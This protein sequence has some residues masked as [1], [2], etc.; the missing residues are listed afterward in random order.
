MGQN[1]DKL[2]GEEQ[3]LSAVPEETSPDPNSASAGDVMEGGSSRE[4]AAGNSGENRG[5]PDAGDPDGCSSQENTHLWVRPFAASEVRQGGA[6][7]KASRGGG[8]VGGWANES[9]RRETEE[10]PKCSPELEETARAYKLH[11]Q[12]KKERDS[13]EGEPH[14][15]EAE[16]E[17]RCSPPDETQDQHL[18][19]DHAFGSEDANALDGSGGDQ[20]SPGT[21]ASG[22]Q[23]IRGHSSSV[24]QDESDSIMAGTA[25]GDIKPSPGTVGR[26]SRRKDPP[27][28][29]SPHPLKN[30]EKKEPLSDMSDSIHSRPANGR[31]GGATK[32]GAPAQEAQSQF[33][34]T[35]PND[36]GTRRSEA[37]D[38]GASS[39]SAAS[40]TSNAEPS[41]I[42]EKLLMRNKKQTILSVVREADMSETDGVDDAARGTVDTTA[43]ELPRAAADKSTIN[44][45]LSTWN[46]KRMDEEPGLGNAADKDRHIKGQDM[47]QPDTSLSP[48][49]TENIKCENSLTNPKSARAQ[50]SKDNQTA[51]LVCDPKLPAKGDVQSGDSLPAEKSN[52]PPAPPKK[53]E[54]ENDSDQTHAVKAGVTQ[55]VGNESSQGPGENVVKRNKK[56]RDDSQDLPK[57]R[58]VSELIKET[59]QLHEKLL[60]QEWS[61]PAEVKG[62]EQGQSVKVAQMK[63]AFDLAQKSPDK[64]IE[65]KPSVRRGK[66]KI[67]L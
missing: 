60:H 13:A 8:G 29:Q 32:E 66:G 65:R 37:A 67:L 45:L 1:Q 3:V 4:A 9:D 30:S 10:N 11:N 50:S 49:V 53:S 55:H 26:L 34:P 43:T 59:M 61:K 22:A 44:T 64:S 31:T 62:E 56:E 17:E 25:A 63:A 57:S 40:P 36:P 58:P 24:E 20:A 23:A 12:T 7:G 46:K 42:L 18:S 35:R 27:P 28:G 33:S 2:D 54:H 39:A 15:S 5:E 19:D 41:S 14:R 16:M 6:A 51:S 38:E 52:C 48:P 21:S 47:G